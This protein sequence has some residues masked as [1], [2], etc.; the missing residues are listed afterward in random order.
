ML[1]RQRKKK[2]SGTRN[3]CCKASSHWKLPSFGPP[4]QRWAR[5]LHKTNNTVLN[6]SSQHLSKFHEMKLRT[7]YK[8]MHVPKSQYIYWRSMDGRTSDKHGVWSPRHWLCS[9]AWGNWHID[10]ELRGQLFQVQRCNSG[11]E[12][13]DFLKFICQHAPWITESLLLHYGVH[14]FVHI[15]LSC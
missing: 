2:T 3:D 13:L 11:C 7:R 10:I 4:R 14:I 9:Q 12:M 8:Q 6:P 5:G 15:L 1:R